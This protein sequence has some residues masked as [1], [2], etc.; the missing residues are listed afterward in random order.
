MF[1]KVKP[2][3]FLLVLV[4]LCLGAFAR[5]LPHRPNFTPVLAVALFSGFYLPRKLV[6][7]LPVLIMFISDLFLGFYSPLVM[8]SV[9]SSVALSALLG[10][11]L[12][13]KESRW[14]A[15]GAGALFS[16]FL[17]FL[18]TNFAV[19]AFTPWYSKTTA[20]LFQCYFLALP[21]FKNTLSSTVFYSV[22]LFSAYHLAEFWLLK[23]FPA[24]HQFVKIDK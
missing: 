15:I 6:W 14:L 1:N 21:F 7:L 23:F 4:L 22:C 24:K 20:G 12:K 3:E 10:L 18:I 11:Y 8:A 5:F 13:K 19:W 17:F 9:Y 16:S 2:I